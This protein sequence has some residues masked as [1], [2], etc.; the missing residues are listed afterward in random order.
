MTNSDNSV[1]STILQQMP[2]EGFMRR[3]QPS[4]RDVQHFVAGS[5][6]QSERQ[7]LDRVWASIW[8]ELTPEQIDTVRSSLRAEGDEWLADVVILKFIRANER[9]ALVRGAIRD[10]SDMVSSLAKKAE[11]ITGELSDISDAL[12]DNT[13]S[14]INI[15]AGEASLRAHEVGLAVMDLKKTLSLLEQKRDEVIPANKRAN[16]ARPVF[17]RE[18]SLLWAAIGLSFKGEHR[19]AFEGVIAGAVEAIEGEVGLGQRE[20]VPGLVDKAIASTVSDET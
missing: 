9:P 12:R 8:D 19:I 3:D 15:V 18:W 17:A 10:V 2:V 6:T 13:A 16:V 20:W 5:L 7:M 11:A 4:M 1:E 14:G